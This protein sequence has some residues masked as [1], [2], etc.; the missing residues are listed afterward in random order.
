MNYRIENKTLEKI[1]T[2]RKF[3]GG[4]SRDIVKAIRKRFQQIRAAANENDL[5]SQKSL[6]FE[7]LKGKRKHQYSIR[8]NDQF[9]MI[10][11]LE[12]EGSS[13]RLIV[14]RVEDYH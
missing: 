10:F 4:Y 9:R 8:L 7:K 11:E 14:K 1:D 12:R 13:N 2:D 5:R 3:N 6:R